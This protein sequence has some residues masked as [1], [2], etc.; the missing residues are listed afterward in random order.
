MAD[1]N[2]QL[3]TS[4]V[5]EFNRAM[6][7][8]IYNATRSAIRTTS[9]LASK[10]LSEKLSEATGI[11]SSLFRKNTTDQNAKPRVQ[12]FISKDMQSSKIWLGYRP[13]SPI[14]VGKLRQ[15]KTGAGA[16][17][18]Y[19]SRGGF[20]AKMQSGH[21][22]IFQRIGGRRVTREAADGHRINSELPI[23]EQFINVPAVNGIMNQVREAAQEE[24]Q[25]RF[26]NKL[27][28]YIERRESAA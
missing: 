7:R 17:R 9:T 6:P 16:G 12:V 23:K 15:E 24:L 8:E 26:S 4:E 28:G 25:T 19:F 11:K 10:L 13:L 20:V 18:T 5:D 22:G 1:F 14:M 2:I 27:R 3:D 21:V